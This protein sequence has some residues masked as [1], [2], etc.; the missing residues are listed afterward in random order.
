VKTFAKFKR[1]QILIKTSSHPYCESN[2]TELI[3]HFDYSVCQK[4]VHIVPY[5][6]QLFSN[7]MWSGF[8]AHSV[9]SDL[10]IDTVSIQL[11]VIF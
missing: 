11:T 5:L 9:F 3:V 10:L 8:L 1:R 2:K 7:V 4:I 6:L